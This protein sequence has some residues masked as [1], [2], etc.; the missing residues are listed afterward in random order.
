MSKFKES[1]L[2]VGA[3]DCGDDSGAP[4]VG[5]PRDQMVWVVEAERVVAFS[6]SSGEHNF[7]S[8]S[9]LE[10]ERDSALSVVPE[11]GCV[12]LDPLAKFGIASKQP[13]SY[14]SDVVQPRMRKASRYSS[15]VGCLVLICSPRICRIT[16]L[17]LRPSPFRCS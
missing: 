7:E 16:L 9:G 14:S 12:P 3:H 11:A 2:I 1:C 13:G 15:T 10:A 5:S 6:H 4:V 8:V 17:I